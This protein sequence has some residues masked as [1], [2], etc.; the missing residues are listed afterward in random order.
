MF[1]EVFQ[2]KVCQLLTCQLAETHKLGDRQFE[3]S[4]LY[5]RR[6]LVGGIHKPNRVHR[7]L[8]FI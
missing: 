3:I 8:E 7:G 4:R 2:N 6:R 5:A 1:C